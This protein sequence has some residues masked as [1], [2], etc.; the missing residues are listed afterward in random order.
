V[1]GVR[2]GRH[3]GGA[4]YNRTGLTACGTA[5]VADSLMAIKK[6]CFDDETVTLRELYDALQTNWE[7]YEQL[8]QRS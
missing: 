6:L 7:G 4:K 3:G 1:H 2:Q 8:R 5:N